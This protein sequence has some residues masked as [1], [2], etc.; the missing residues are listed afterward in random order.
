[1]RSL[2]VKIFV[3]FWAAIVLVAGAAFLSATWLHSRPESEQARLRAMAGMFT[4]MQ[5]RSLVEILERDGPDEVREL[6]K[7]WDRFPDSHS[8]L[9]DDQGREL[10]GCAPFKGAMDAVKLVLETDDTQVIQTDEMTIVAV[11]IRGKEDRL[12][13]MARELPVSGS[14]SMRD[15]PPVSSPPIGPLGDVPRQGH[16]PRPDGRPPPM[17]RFPYDMLMSQPEIVVS[18]LG[19]VILTGGL[20]CYGLARHM[21]NPVRRLRSAARRFANGDLSVRLGATGR[22][23]EIGDLS[24][25]FDFMAD[26]L[27][28]LVSGQRQILRD[29]SHELRSPLARLSVALGIAERGSPEAVREA[30]QRIEKESLRLNELIGHLLTL[31]RLESGVDGDAYGPV[32]LHTLIETIARDADFEA[33]GRDRT[34]LVAASEPCVVHGSNELLRRAIEN[35][36]RNGVRHTASGTA[37][38]IQ[39]RRGE[40]N[41]AVVHVRDHGPGIPDSALA[42]IFIPFRRVVSD[43]GEPFEGAGLGLAITDRAVRAHGGT[44]RAI[45]ANGGGLDVEIQLPLVEQ[46][47]C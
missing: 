47:P 40:S 35:V 6:F 32:E 4:T 27:D 10:L 25:D 9:F 31:S 45:N 28:R 38:E 11:P 8:L 26:R 33:K 23:D 7:R 1:M 22:H 20:V 2:F 24:R 39:L 37:V 44:V 5:G 43:N 13:V 21:T 12:Y 3:W 17:S 30:L 34:V 14:A 18:I 46:P 36:I 29:I 19:A 42:D 15:V 16:R 41:L